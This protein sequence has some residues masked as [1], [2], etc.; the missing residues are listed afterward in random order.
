[1]DWELAVTIAKWIAQEKDKANKRQKV[2][3]KI[4]FSDRRA[5]IS[6]TLN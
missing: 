5:P 6:E 4:K 2:V 1:M 3:Y